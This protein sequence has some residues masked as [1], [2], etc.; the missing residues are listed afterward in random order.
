MLDLLQNLCINRSKKAKNDKIILLLANFFKKVKCQPCKVCLLIFQ[1]LVATECFIDL[2]KLNLLKISL[3]WSKSVKLTLQ[4]FNTT[5]LDYIFLNVGS[6]MQM[7]SQT[8]VQRPPLGKKW[9]LFGGGCYSLVKLIC[10]I[11]KFIRVKSF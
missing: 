9:L 4:H 6:T 10:L 7:Y 3:P 2:G 11:K 8:C 5:S 1:V